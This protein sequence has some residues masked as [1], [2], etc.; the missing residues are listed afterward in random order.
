MYFNF[1]GKGIIRTFWL[2]GKGDVD[3]TGPH[4]N[5]EVN[6]DNTGTIGDKLIPRDCGDDHSEAT[7]NSKTP[8]SKHRKS[9]LNSDN[10]GYSLLTGYVTDRESTQKIPTNSGVATRRKRTSRQYSLDQYIHV[11]DDD[12]TV[13]PITASANNQ[14]SSR[15]HRSNICSLV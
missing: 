6:D 1:Q 7:G 2:L 14:R 4:L 15:F 5:A 9:L 11:T 8:I 3:V 13:E 12:D 10:Q